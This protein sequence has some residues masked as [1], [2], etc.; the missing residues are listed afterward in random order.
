LKK[1]ILT[2]RPEL[3]DRRIALIETPDW[4]NFT[5]PELALQS[6]ALD[7]PLCELYGMPVLQY[8]NYFIGFL[9]MYH[10][11]PSVKN[12]SPHKYFDGHV[13]CQLSYSLNGKHFQRTLRQPIFP[14]GSPGTYDHGCIYPSSFRIDDD[15][16]VII[17]SSASRREHGYN[18]YGTG[19][20][21][22]HRLRADGFVYL[23]STGGCGQIG[24]RPVLWQ[25]GELH[26]NVQCP[27][28]KA[29]VR[30]TDQYGE[31]IDG[32][33][34]AECKPLNGD[35]TD[36]IP[37]WESG[38]L[39]ASLKNRTIRIEVEVQSGRLYSLRGEFIP[40]V[41]AECER[42]NQEGITPA[43]RIGY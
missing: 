24:T 15:R 29:S 17:Y 31:V 43:R 10:T 34:Y 27:D 26:I 14:N 23:E 12:H 2:T 33:S 20:I 32:Y 39:V 41:S 3:T 16:S 38:R 37:E 40:L 36:W 13:D 28:G 8:D 25:D 4:E 30:I 1:Y 7:Y 19:T 18:E 21:L 9:W 42:F 11:D 5:K 6:D 22:V 35:S